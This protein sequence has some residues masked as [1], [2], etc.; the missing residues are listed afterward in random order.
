MDLRPLGRGPHHIL[1]GYVWLK[2]CKQGSHWVTVSGYSKLST[3]K[4]G[5]QAR[6]KLCD[7]A[8]SK[9][10]HEKHR[11]KRNAEHKKWREENRELVLAYDKKYREENPEREKARQ[12]K[13]HEEN[14]EKKDKGMQRGVLVRK[15]PP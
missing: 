10:Y 4:D 1:C 6:C 3:T 5:L 8:N 2:W 14:P 11:E 12:K 15:V 9:K 13:Y 7:N